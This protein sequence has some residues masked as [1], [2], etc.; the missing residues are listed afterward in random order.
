MNSITTEL[1]D[2]L[3]KLPARSAASRR[4]FLEE[5]RSG[6]ASGERG[7]ESLLPFALADH[8]EDVVFSATSAYVGVVRD[9]LERNAAAHDAT[10]WVRRGL[11]LNRGAVFAAL[12]ALGDD[13]INERLI[14]LR[15]A[16]SADD[17]ATVCRRAARRPCE[18]SRAFLREWHELLFGEGAALEREHVAATLGIGQAQVA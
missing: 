12:L 7:A 16:L 4:Q 17:V 1:I 3:Q 14:P 6:V 11:A 13:G 15:L 9:A 8:D 18:R 5:T 10:E 2:Y